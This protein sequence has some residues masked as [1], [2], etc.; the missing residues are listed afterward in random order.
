MNILEAELITI[1]ETKGIDDIVRCRRIRFLL[2][3]LNI[4]EDFDLS[5][6]GLK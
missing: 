3:K 6:M 5:L 4:L 1:F 2:H